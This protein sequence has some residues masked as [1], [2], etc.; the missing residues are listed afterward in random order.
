MRID[1]KEKRILK[2][3]ICKRLGIDIVRNINGIS[4]DS[5]NIKK[6]D[7]FIA[8]QGHKSHGI[9]FIDNQHLNDLS[10]IVSDKKIIDPKIVLVPDS[11]DF[12]VHIA[13]EFRKSLKSKV[14]GI[15]GTNG[16]TSTK[17]LLVK[18]LKTKFDV[19][20]SHGNYNSTISLPLSLLGCDSKSS[21]CVLEMGA[22]RKQE[23]SFLCAV[24]KPDFGLIT[25]I[26]ESH[27]E[28]YKNFEELINTKLAL[29]DSLV[30]NGG[31]YFLNKDDSNITIKEDYQK[32]ITYSNY[33]KSSDYFADTS[34][35]I[36]G[37]VYINDYLFNVPYK[38]DIFA[39]NFLASYSIA[40][41][42]GVSNKKIQDAL[43]GFEY[44]KGR[45]EI[46]EID[47]NTIIDDTYNANLNS[48]KAGIKE[49]EL[50][51]G[52]KPIVLILGDMLDLGDSSKAHHLE[53][54]KFISELNFIDKVYCTGLMTSYTVDS[55][56]NKN[57]KFKH[58][59]DTSSLIESLNED[60]NNNMIFYFKGSRGMEMEKIINKVFNR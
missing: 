14:I 37:F 5:R 55:I 16:K 49:L 23:I 56:T 43:L 42:L 26:S 3:I 8:L 18:F 33:D 47:G 38:S 25:N 6:G 52:E 1:I 60:K 39:S 40:S 7:L 34:Q 44:P 17:E 20:Y 21:Y 29:Y 48:M 51:K 22:S 19:N 9:D 30:D 45:G 35:I 58:F 36:E 57:I 10:L 59:I 15:T 13:T 11:K 12:L 27:L 32:I 46:L 4:I 24:A 50:I 41:S 31:A 28:G 53:L 2:S 54:G